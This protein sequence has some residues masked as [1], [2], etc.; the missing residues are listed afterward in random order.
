MLGAAV[1]YQASTVA[2][3]YFAVH[4]LD[5]D[6][7]VAAVL[8]FAPAVAMAQVLPLSLSGLGVR[9]GM[10]VIL[11]HPLGVSTGRAVAI[12]LLWYAMM[13]V[14]SLFGAPAFAVGHRR[15]ARAQ[16]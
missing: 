2:V 10:L 8:A 1:L 5:V 14:V 16:S 9:E 6:I 12:G 4:A 3:V 7:P 11:L 15:P 13:L